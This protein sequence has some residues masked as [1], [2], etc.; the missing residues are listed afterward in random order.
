MKQYIIIILILF[1]CNLGLNAQILDFSHGFGNANDDLIQDITTNVWGETFVTGAFQGSVDF[2]PGSGTNIQSSSSN[3]YDIFFSRFDQNGNFIWVNRIGGTGLDRAYSITSESNF[4]YITGIFSGTVDFNPSSATNSLVSSG[5]NDIFIAKYDTAGNYIWAKKIGGSGFDI[6]NDITL[7]TSG[8]IYVTGN[9]QGTVDFNPGSGTNNLSASGSNDAFI[10]RLNSAGNY[11]FALKFG[12]SGAA[13]FG[14]GINIDVN[15]NILICGYFSGSADFNP[16]SS[17]SNLSSA[18]N[19]DFFVVK[20]NSSST[21]QWAIRIGSSGYEYANSIVSDSNS[22]VFLTGSF[23]GTVDFNP[24][25]ST[26]NLS[27][28]GST[29]AYVLKLNNSGAYQSAFKLGNTED[30]YGLALSVGNDNSLYTSGYFSGNVDFDPGADTNVLTSFAFRDA[31][32]LKLNSSLSHLWAI[33][34]GGW[35]QDAANSI[36]IDPSNN[37]WCTG[38]FEYDSYMNPATNNQDSLVS[39]GLGD[40]FISK[41]SQC[42]LPVAPTVITACESFFWSVTN[43]TYFSSGIYSDTLVNSNNCESILTLDLT[44]IQPTSSTQ[45]VSACSSYLWNG[46]NYTSSGT[47]FNIIP[48][49]LGC[50]SIMTLNLTII[51]PTSSTQTVS[52]CSSY[53]WNGNNYTNSGTYFNTIPNALGCDSIMTLNLTINNISDL[54]TTVSGN[55]ITSNN[56]FAN[57]QWLD[58]NND[59]EP[60]LGATTNSF[61]PSE[62]G[63]FAVEISENGCLDTTSCVLVNIVSLLEIRPAGKWFLYPNPTLGTVNIDFNKIEMETWIIQRNTLGQEVKRIKYSATNKIEFTFEGGSGIYYLDIIN[64]TERRTFK[65]IK[66]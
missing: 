11:Q 20:L 28:A 42:P 34:W 48:N 40:N 56:I 25:S 24:G 41:F 39:N 12:G 60:I 52:A 36:S 29:D 33:R 50:D 38:T 30:D 61:T 44:I 43:Q 16:G 49:A 63:N 13:V 4:I 18:G 59:F 64:E 9:F 21:F 57:Y 6:G 54:S 62:S 1:S 45:N 27:S 10:L 55:T 15:Q 65:V 14:S 17:N 58:C 3:S 2:N 35:G 31:Y 51:Q 5:Q 8:N 37:I 66:E 7:D 26:N 32:L 47:Y 19:T 53:L 46:N 22:N 23:E